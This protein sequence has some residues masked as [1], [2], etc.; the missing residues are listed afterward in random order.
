M[1]RNE[2]P[3]RAGRKFGAALSAS[4]LLLLFAVLVLVAGIVMTAV[5]GRFGDD[6]D[7]TRWSNVGEAF[8]AVNS[9][10]S[11]LAV[12][13][14]LITWTLQSR[15]LAVQRRILED[16]Q[17]VLRR[18][19]DVGVRNSHVMLT[20]MAIEDPN[21]AAV[22]PNHG[23][24]DPVV[25]AQHMYANLLIQHAW[26]QCT[27]GLATRE[28]MISNLRFL[29]ASPKV[30]DFWR[31]TVNSRTSIYVESSGEADLAAIADEI[32]AEYE[33]VLACSSSSSA[34]S[35]PSPRARDEEPNPGLA[36]V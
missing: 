27:T 18:S 3:A 33:A 12:A 6:A 35:D 14:L 32:W 21:L 30:R 25:Q 36:E 4:A 7:W 34:P 8:G 17:L 22:W 26:L 10:V 16:A 31:D 9:V 23:R 28:E 15:D 29:F 5:L 2:S 24:T 19:A 11:A 20:R 13:A 1:D